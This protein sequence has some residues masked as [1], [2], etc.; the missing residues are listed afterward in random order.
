MCCP[1]LAQEKRNE[2]SSLR[3]KTHTG[4]TVNIK[5]ADFEQP[6]MLTFCSPHTPM[7]DRWFL[8][9]FVT[10]TS[11]EAYGLPRGGAGEQKVNIC[12]PENNFLY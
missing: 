3:H 11:L 9:W 8:S 4:S 1:D 6:K 12:F 5:K 2:M 7:R 10:A